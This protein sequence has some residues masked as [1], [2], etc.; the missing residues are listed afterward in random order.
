M[1]G[2]DS[3]ETTIVYDALSRKTSMNDPNM[4]VWLYRYDAAGNLRKQRDAANVMTC[5]HYDELN[6]LKG[7]SFHSG[8]SDPDADPGFCGRVTNYNVTYGY[9][10]GV[11]GKGR[12]TGM[13]DA[14]GNTS[15]EYDTRGRMAKETKA[16][17]GASGSP[18]VTR[19]TS[20]DSMD[21]VRTMQYPDGEG[22]TFSYTAQGP[23]KG[24][25][26]TSVYVGDTLY[27]PLGQATDRYL[28]ST[29]GLIRQKYTY[30]AGENFR[31]TALQS[32]VGPN[33]N[34]LQNISYTYDDTGNVLT[35]AD[36]AAYGGNQTQTFTYDA[37]NR[38]TRGYTS[39]N[40]A[41]WYDEDYT[42]SAGGNITTKGKLNSLWW[43][44][45]YGEQAAD[46]PQGA[47]SK[48]HAVVGADAAPYFNRYCY[49]QNGN[50]VRRRLGTADVLPRTADALA[51]STDQSHPDTQVIDTYLLA[52]DEENR[53]REVSLNGGIVA[54][55]T[56]DGDGNRVKAVVNGVT[57][58][59]VGNTYER[60][61]NT[62]RKYYYAGGVRIALRTGG[63]T[64]YLLGDHLG[65]TN[66]TTNSSGVQVA[67]LLY[68]PWGETRYDFG[69]TPTT[70]RFTGQREDATI[71]LYFYNARFYDPYLNR[72]IQ[73]D[74]IVP[75][76][77][78]PQSLNRYSY[79]LNNPLRYSDS[80]GHC[81]PLTPV[82]VILA[83]LGTG[84][85]L[86]GDD[87]SQPVS[88]EVAN[89]ARLGGA[90]LVTTVGV[91][92][93]S[94]IVGSASTAQAAT[95]GTGA[96]CAD[97][98]CTNEV[99]GASQLA[100]NAAVNSAQSGALLRQQYESV[101]RTLADRGAQLRSA[102]RPLEEIA[103]TLHAE[104]RA[105]GE[106][107]KVM[108][109]PDKLE[110]IYARNIERY[111]DKLGPSVEWLIERGLRQG[112]TMEEIWES[113]ISSAS[114]PGGQDIIPHLLGQ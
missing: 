30:T 86:S 48:P 83:L 97:G 114:R 10:T 31:L 37:L 70:W 96:A 64:Y 45:S 51:G 5:F 11:N 28:G 95:A 41:G 21:R 109:P 65:G 62:V 88:P 107:F 27:N 44:Y 84:L 46:C 36:S 68:K 78:N 69:V 24:V 73:P 63:Q 32:G 12:R 52:Y 42:Y 39:G 3:A 61:G 25:S 18:Y 29:T 58:V 55:Y 49:D 9:D 93:G 59:Y 57:T 76:P 102:G 100:Q 99:R 56:Y 91:G 81:G 2:P 53:L 47:L 113:I 6:R 105:L 79:V 72:W 89:S 92:S 106:Q 40:K 17:S 13:N 82:C 16:I 20:Y 108:T 54:T 66:V 75:D 110:Q 43:Y 77:S 103:R 35:I 98:D 26:G 7:K 60:E 1:V 19:W 104:R 15:W 111:G 14:S 50:M 34:N 8:V 87:T 71:G 94:A 101:V 80:S 112:K 33:Y 4:G 67:S 74:T 85:L 23:I 38:L 90:L 22:V